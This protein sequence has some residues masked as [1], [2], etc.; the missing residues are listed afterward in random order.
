M[1]AT[2]LRKVQ[3]GI[4]RL[5]SGKGLPTDEGAVYDKSITLDAGSL[6]TDDHLRH[7]S[8]HGHEDHRTHPQPG[9]SLSDASQK[10]ALEKALTYMGLQPGQSLLG[11]KVDVV[12]IGSCTNSRISDLRLAASLLKGRKVAEGIRV[13]GCPRFAGCEETG[14]SRRAW[15]KSSRK[16]APNGAKQAVRCAL[17]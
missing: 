5:P 10:A 1:D 14:R 3:T 17:P 2:L 7:E 11:Q 16:L 9:K 13:Y 12:F 15:I 6:G 4:K 8:W